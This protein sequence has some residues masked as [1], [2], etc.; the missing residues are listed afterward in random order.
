MV[1]AKLRS[2]VG[3]RGQLS[4]VSDSRMTTTVFILDIDFSSDYTHIELRTVL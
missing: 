4:D 2:A 3:D 1:T